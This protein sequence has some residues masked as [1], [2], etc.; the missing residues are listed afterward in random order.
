MRPIRNII[1]MTKRTAILAISMLVLSAVL[2]G[3]LYLRQ[4]TD[5]SISR[6]IGPLGGTI[7]VR[8]DEQMRINTKRIYQLDEGFDVITG[9]HT[10]TDIFANV[11]DIISIKPPV[12]EN[13]QE[14][15][16][17]Y[18]TKGDFTL[19]ATTSTDILEV[20]YSGDCVITEG[21]GI[22]SADTESKA[23]K[24]VLSR[25][26][27]DLNSIKLGD[28]I[29]VDAYSE[30][31]EIEPITLTVGGIYEYTQPIISTAKYSFQMPQ[32]LIYAPLSTITYYFDKSE[33]FLF[34]DYLF[35]DMTNTSKGYVTALESRLND[36]A[37]SYFGA[38]VTKVRKITL[39]S[40]TPK[41][42]AGALFRMSQIL[43]ISVV[44]V[45][46]CMIVS[47]TLIISFHIN[48]RRR[49]LAVL[50][51]LGAKRSSVARMMVFEMLIVFAAAFLVATLI[52]GAI[53]LCFGSEIH[54]LMELDSFGGVTYATS[55]ES[56][57]TR[58][59]ESEMIA[60]YYGDIPELLREYLVPTAVSALIT[61]LPLFIAAYF[62][63]L[64]VLKRIEVMRVVGGR[65]E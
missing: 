64:M 9:L 62:G 29:T 51:A 8:S 24:A 58:D 56:I 44:A 33:S 45:V 14:E 53:V 61:I 13:K 65:A 39:H 11:S 20:F 55:H 7:E 32:N 42:E 47:L 40:F 54:M 3:V 30:I 26:L 28:T 22:T 16:G 48:A 12:A 6:M 37:G 52:F 15:D 50:C 18:S 4:I 27:A 36:F 25:E 1:R 63:I 46:V 49:E 41:N 5:E 31:G 23:L 10:S 19:C 59:I 21:V 43:G 35:L 34:S 2:M 38:G 57:V 60:T 17:W